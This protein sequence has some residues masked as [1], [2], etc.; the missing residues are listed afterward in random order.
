VSQHTNF[1]LAVDVG[2][3]NDYTALTIL[4]SYRTRERGSTEF[5]PVKEDRRHDLIH[6]ERFREIPYPEQIRRI[7]ERYRELGQHA[8]GV[9]GTTQVRLAVDATGVGKPILDAFREAGLRPRGILITGGET[10]SFADGLDRVPK[11]ELVTTLQVA[12][13][14]RRLRI[15]EELP[16]AETLLRELRGFRVK[17]S[18]SGHASFGNDVGAWREADHDDLVLSVALAVWMVEARKSPSLSAVRQAA[19]LQVERRPWKAP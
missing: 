8:R 2:Q 1:V 4:Q 7:A 19:G 9:A 11:R 16:L 5:D 6:L 15:A 18:L 3:A 13:Q 12:L 14:A 17:I 10:A